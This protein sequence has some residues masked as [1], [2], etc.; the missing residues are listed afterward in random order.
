MCSRMTLPAQGAWLR[1]PNVV[2]SNLSRSA[3]ILGK[4]ISVSKKQNKYMHI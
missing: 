3:I 4:A 2:P 1:R